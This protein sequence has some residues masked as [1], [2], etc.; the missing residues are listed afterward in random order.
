MER[1]NQDIRDYAKK[2]GVFLWE[3]AQKLGYTDGYFSKKLR[4]EMPRTEKQFIRG[5]IKGISDTR[6]G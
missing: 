5:I 4:T 1:A 2:K 6:E 3:V